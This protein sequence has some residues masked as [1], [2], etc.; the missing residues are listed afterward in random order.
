MA[1]VVQLKREM[2][3]WD[4][5]GQNTRGFTNAVYSS[6][7]IHGMGLRPRSSDED[8]IGRQGR[9]LGRWEVSLDISG[10]CKTLAIGRVRGS[11]PT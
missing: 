10:S 9:E 8:T 11:V 5:S 7:P 2:Q 4:V 6:S 1:G 3:G